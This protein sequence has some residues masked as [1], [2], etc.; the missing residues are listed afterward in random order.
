V[1]VLQGDGGN[2]GVSVGDDGVLMIDD[3]FARLSADIDVAL[4]GLSEEAPRFLINTHWHGDHTGG[5]EH[6]G[7]GASIVAHA[8]VRRRLSAEA[9][10]EGRVSAPPMPAG[11][12]P[13]VT[14]DDG[15]SLHFNGEEVKLFHVPNAHTD[16]DTIAFFRRSDVVSTGL[17]YDTL[18]YPRFDPDAGGSIGG[19]LDGLNLVIEL[20]IP[21]EGQTGGTVVVPGRGRLSDETDVADYRD[22]VTIVRDRIAAMVAE[23]QSLAQVRAAE[24]TADYDGIYDRAGSEW[25]RDMFVDAVYRDLSGSSR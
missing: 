23:G 7:S 15:L 21:G 16:G 9:G 14:F 8:N 13:V 25:T 19:I 4:D 12:L 22:M 1:H 10:V 18:A 6:F 5:N 11:G 24:P 2:I 20:A 17:I 3:K